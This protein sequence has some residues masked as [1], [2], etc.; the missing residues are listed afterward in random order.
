M[1]EIPVARGLMV[2]AAIT[3]LVGV[4]VFRLLPGWDALIT[5]MEPGDAWKVSAFYHLF[6]ALFIMGGTLLFLLE[7]KLLKGRPKRYTVGIAAA[8][9]ITALHFALNVYDLKVSS[10]VVLGLGLVACSWAFNMAIF[11]VMKLFDRAAE[12]TP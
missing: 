8:A 5:E 9:S 4:I 10:G 3:M 1:N 11:Y 6:Y 7:L 12:P 2:S